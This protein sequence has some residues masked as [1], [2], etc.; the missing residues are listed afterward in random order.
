M[1]YALLAASAALAAVVAGNA[2]AADAIAPV[3][4]PVAPLPAAPT[5]CQIRDLS[6]FNYVGNDC[7]NVHHLFGNGANHAGITL[8]GWLNGG[9]MGNADSPSTG[10]N[11]PVTFTDVDKG[12]FNQGYISL[13]RTAPKNNRGWFVGGRIDALYGSDFF[14]TTAAG[15]DGTS[16]GNTPRWG[17]S[18]STY[19]AALPQ[20]YAE[21]DYN[22]LQ[23]KAGHFYTII[24]HES[25][26]AKYNFFYSHS[27]AFQYGEP[28]TSTGILASKPLSPNWTLTGGVVNSWNDF[29]A[30]GQGGKDLNNFLG[31]VA[32]ANSNFGAALNLQ[33]GNDSDINV[34]PVSAPTSNRTVVDF[35]AS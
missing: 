4:R 25:V 12:Q 21:I 34:G 32:Y 6:S 10:F 30:P 33:T 9:I 19:G 22:D 26:M 16:A 28:A 24:G 18:G 17:N 27:Y 14:F 5:V 35:I 1:K 31:G 29:A 7:G 2:L 15:L 3:P 13:A 23:V 20:A 11:G 8:D